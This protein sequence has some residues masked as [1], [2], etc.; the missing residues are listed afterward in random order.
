MILR[1][2]KMG[3]I[4][5]EG[6]ENASPKGYRKEA[7]VPFQSVI[8]GFPRQHSRPDILLGSGCSV[9]LTHNK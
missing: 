7:R 4:V 9:P 2:A 8:L 1:I 3:R 6:C 5:E